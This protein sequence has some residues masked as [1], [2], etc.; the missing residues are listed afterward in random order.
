MGA[1]AQ[2]AN[3]K[4]FESVYPSTLTV[5]QFAADEQ[6]RAL[7][8]T[9]QRRI[10]ELQAALRSNSSE[11]ERLKAENADKYHRIG[12]L[13]SDLETLERVERINIQDLAHV[14]TKLVAITQAKGVAPDPAT[15][16]I[17]RRRGWISSRHQSSAQ[18]P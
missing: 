16:E 2:R 6:L 5:H 17:L 13:Q 7:S 1:T 10:D 4:V 11:I 3:S 12:I 8:R 14:T 18:L 9:Y 15:I